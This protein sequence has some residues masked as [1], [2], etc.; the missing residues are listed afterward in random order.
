MLSSYLFLGEYMDKYR[1][2]AIV[3]VV[4]GIGV[5]MHS[6]KILA[7]LNEKSQA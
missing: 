7:L 5:F 4:V 6:G 2:I 3:L 1:L